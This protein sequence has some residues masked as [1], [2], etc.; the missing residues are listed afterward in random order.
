MY[1]SIVIIKMKNIVLNISE[2]A[3]INSRPSETGDPCNKSE[4][5]KNR[6][7]SGNSLR[8]P[9][10]FG[11]LS[12]F[13][14]AMMFAAMPAS[15]VTVKSGDASVLKTPSFALLEINF[16]DAKVGTETFEEYQ[17]RR[18][19][20]FIRDWPDA[21]MQTYASF[22][23]FFNKKNKKGMQLRLEEGGD[24]TYKMVINVSYLN[25]GDSFSVMLP[26]SNRKAGGMLMNGS[27]DIIDIGTNNVVCSL[28][29]DGIKGLGLNR[30]ADRLQSMFNFLADNIYAV[31]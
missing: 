25:M 30:T 9:L 19:E 13:C 10:L 18:G 29:F 21:V 20:N 17:Q 16:S 26:Y 27:I 4:R 28:A 14:T 6:M 12:L 31:K 2:T 3:A 11:L 5:L 1:R 24:V 22:K 15:L 7:R 23:N 8:K